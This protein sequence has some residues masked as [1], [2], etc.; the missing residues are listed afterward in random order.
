MVQTFRDRR[1]L[2][3]KL[4][5]EIPGLDIV[6]PEGAFYA[7]CSYDADIDCKELALRIL[8][9][10]QVVVTPGDAFGSLGAGHIRISYATGEE[11]LREGMARIGKVFARL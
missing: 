8:K 5:K 1:D 4:V 2:V 11:L 10:Q 3:V 6:K 7:F 9:E